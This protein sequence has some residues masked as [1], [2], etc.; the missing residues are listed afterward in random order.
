MGN[1]QQGIW[2][3]L[4]AIV[5][6]TGPVYFFFDLGAEPPLGFEEV[7]LFAAA[8]GVDFLATFL[9]DPAFCEV[10]ERCFFASPP[11]LGAF[12]PAT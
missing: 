7:G 2:I 12:F 8:V 3:S 1:H 10:L 6:Y 4:G 5:Q 9:L 11:V